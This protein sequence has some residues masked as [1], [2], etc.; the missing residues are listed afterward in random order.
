MSTLEDLRRKHQ[1]LLSNETQKTSEQKISEFASFKSDTK[2]LVRILPGAESSEDQNYFK[3]YTEANIHKINLS[4]KEYRNYQCR[5]TY[6]ESCPVCD[7]MYQLWER[8]RE[9]KL[10]KGE[11]SK[12]G[13]MA[14][15]IKPRP[16]YYMKVVVRSLIDTKDDNGNI[17]SPVKFLAMSK[18]LFDRVLAAVTDPDLQDESDPD[19][20]TILS[21]EN[22]NDFE[23]AVTKKGEYNSFVESKAKIKKTRAGT[24][25]QI[26][27]WMDSPLNLNSLVKLEEYDEGKKLAQEVLAKLEG[28]GTSS[29]ESRETPPWESGDDNNDKFNKEMKV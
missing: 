5:R 10:P 1:E 17:Q 29:N 13:N 18:E 11:K 16:R 19:N 8:H 2:N 9:L 3:F 25:K 15:K 4:D 23:V 7:L 27:E 26:A 21:L 14:T 12:Y 28:E 20:T 22:G 6:N 24:P